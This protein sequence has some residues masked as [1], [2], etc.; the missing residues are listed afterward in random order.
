[1]EPE[2]ELKVSV[3]SVECVYIKCFYAEHFIKSERSLL[4]P[5]EW[6]ESDIHAF[7]GYILYPQ[8]IL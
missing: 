3:A 4:G 6:I 2:S 1:M 8:D 5:V 7:D